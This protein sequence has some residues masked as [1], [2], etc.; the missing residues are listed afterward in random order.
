MGPSVTSS[1]SAAPHRVGRVGPAGDTR[2]GERGAA[3][4]RRPSAT[5]ARRHPDERKGP[6]GAELRRLGFIPLIVVD[7]V[8]YI[9]FDPEANVMLP[10]ALAMGWWCRAGPGSVA[11]TSGDMARRGHGR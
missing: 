7:E 3:P 8:G 2:R 9:L 5:Q 10:A 1:A 4:R 11:L 6:R